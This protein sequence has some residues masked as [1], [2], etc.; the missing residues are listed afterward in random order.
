MASSSPKSPLLPS[1]LDLHMP[2]AV[3]EYTLPN[4]SRKLYR[5]VQFLISKFIVQNNQVLLER[6]DLLLGICDEVKSLS[7]RCAS[8][9]EYRQLLECIIES[10]RVQTLS[11]SNAKVYNAVIVQDALVK[12]CDYVV[13]CVIGRVRNMKTLS[14]VARRHFALGGIADKEVAYFIADALQ[15]W[16]EAFEPREDLFPTIPCIYRVNP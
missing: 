5:Q 14:K 11:L 12:N 15:A 3:L 13:H 10:L 4:A 8:R 2:L 9:E 1:A 6:H 7:V 16:G